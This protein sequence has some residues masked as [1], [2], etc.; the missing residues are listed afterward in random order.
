MAIPNKKCPELPSLTV[1]SGNFFQIDQWCRPHVGLDLDFG[2]W[3]LA[4]W[5]GYSQL[6][7][8]S[9][10]IS[11]YTSKFHIDNMNIY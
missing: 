8:S 2:K 10:N 5:F 4:T 1:H 7:R 6:L 11:K 9:V 3:N